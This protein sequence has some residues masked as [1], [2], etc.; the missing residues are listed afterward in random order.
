MQVLVKPQEEVVEVVWSSLLALGLL[1]CPF[2][3]GCV[4]NISRALQGCI[5][6]FLQ[7]GPLKVCADQPGLLPHPQPTEGMQKPCK[8]KLM[9]P[10][11]KLCDWASWPSISHLVTIF[12]PSCSAP[13]GTALALKGALPFFGCHP[14]WVVRISAVNMAHLGEAQVPHF[15]QL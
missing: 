4:C 3:L 13:G 5:S 7:D 2:G 9:G 1:V 15:E 10:T 6:S 11:L 8:R 14:G 12:G